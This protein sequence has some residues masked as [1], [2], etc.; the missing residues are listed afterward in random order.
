M[1]RTNA[2]TPRERRRRAATPTTTQ[3]LHATQYMALH[4]HVQIDGLTPEDAMAQAYRLGVSHGSAG[5]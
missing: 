4:T 1:K 3:K 5:A 2:L